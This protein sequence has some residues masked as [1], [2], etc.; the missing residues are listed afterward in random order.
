MKTEM[1]FAVLQVASFD[2]FKERFDAFA[3]DKDFKKLQDYAKYCFAHAAFLV[4]VLPCDYGPEDLNLYFE[5]MNSTGKQLSPLEVVKGRWFAKYSKDWNACMNFDKPL[6]ASA[7]TFSGDELSPRPLSLYDVVSGWTNGENGTED[8]ADVESKNRLV[9]KDDVLALHA[10]R[11]L[12]RENAECI[13]LDQ[14]KLISTF[15]TF[16]KADQ[17]KKFIDELWNYRTW[18][19]KNIIY[20]KDDGGEYEYA[21]RRDDDDADVKEYSVEDVSR[22]RMKQF[23]A[24]LYVSSGE[25]QEWVL[26][27]YWRSKQGEQCLTLEDLRALDAL[28]HKDALLDLECMRY[29]HVSRYWFW[30]LDFLLWEKNAMGEELFE[31]EGLENEAVK[32]YKFKRHISIEH[33]HPQSKGDGI[34][35]YRDETDSAKMLHGFGNLAMISGDANSAQSNDGIGTK[36]GRVKDWLNS[37]RLESIKMLLMFSLCKGIESNWTVEM[38]QKHG[39][40]MLKLLQEDRD[41]WLP[42]P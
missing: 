26:D 27:A 32:K 35:G 24:M 19:D 2:R 25:A 3:C 18:I 20:L 21:F 30:K 28:K 14:H 4:N 12:C 6:A 7:K 38:A 11:I 42:V 15:D 34:W 23:Q 33:L 17:E 8:A 5:K 36:F 39:E 31:R 41:D 1:A 40:E 9:M 13:S 10:L 29:P 22:C 16:F 37:G